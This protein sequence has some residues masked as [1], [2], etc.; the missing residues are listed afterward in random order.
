MTAN[1]KPNL[2]NQPETGSMDPAEK[3]EIDLQ[4]L[5]EELLKLLKDE[6]RLDRERQ[7]VR[8]S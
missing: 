3:R 4:A 5:A 8:R 1:D 6:A 2:Q 7:G